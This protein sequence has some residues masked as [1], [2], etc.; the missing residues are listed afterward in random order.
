MALTTLFGVLLLTLSNVSGHALLQEPP[1]RAGMQTNALLGDKIT[2]RPPTFQNLNGCLNS[3]AGPISRSYC[4]STDALIQW[5]ITLD[6]VNDP[7]VRVALG[8]P[9]EAEFRVLAEGVDVHLNQTLVR[10]PNEPCANCV[11][12]WMWDSVLDGGY[13]VG[14]SDITIVTD[15]QECIA[16]AAA[17]AIPRSC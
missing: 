4:G 2:P 13:Y 9:N 1:A 6:H 8:Y 10:L 7:G 11:L 15:T 14:C 5:V 3:T 17:A 12:H 16:E